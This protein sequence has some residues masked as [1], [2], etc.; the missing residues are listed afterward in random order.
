V[1]PDVSALRVK[2]CVKGS[3]PRFVE[4]GGKADVLA[5]G[6]VR[7]PNAWRVFRFRGQ[8]LIGWLQPDGALRGWRCVGST[9]IREDTNE[10]DGRGKNAPRE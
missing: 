8:P 4:V 1:G 10:E 6:F 5:P 3:D 9:G 7:V 2:E